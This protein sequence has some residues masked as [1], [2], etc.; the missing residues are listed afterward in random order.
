MIKN[1]LGHTLPILE[2]EITVMLQKRV[3]GVGRL[4]V[5]ELIYYNFSLIRS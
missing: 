4:I 2:R 5:F 1:K 3:V